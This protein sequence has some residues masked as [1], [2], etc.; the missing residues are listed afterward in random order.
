MKPKESNSPTVE[1]SSNKS[2]K[3]LGLLAAASIPISAMTAW[4]I[5]DTSGYFSNL[6]DV[7]SN[8]IAS[9]ETAVLMV[10]YGNTLDASSAAAIGSSLSTHYDDSLVVG[11]FNLPA[12]NLTKPNSPT[13]F[14]VGIGYAGTSSPWIPTK[15]NALEVY[16]DGT[17]IINERQGDV[18]MGDF[19]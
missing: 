3:R 6:V 18:L 1:T 17:V 19:E 11:S 16:K 15:K 7:G 8:Y 5:S 10:G 13:A 4:A 9:S 14:V 2:K 12:A